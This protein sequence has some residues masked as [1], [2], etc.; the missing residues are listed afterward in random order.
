ML[1]ELIRNLPGLM[2]VY[3][4]FILAVASPGPSNLQ[5]MATSMERGRAAGSTLALGVT[6]GSLTWGILAAVGV[7]GIVV[8]HPGAL[9]AI[10]IVGGLY[11]LFL[12]WRSARSAMRAEMPPVKAAASGRRTFLRG[13][14]MHITN[15]KA[16]LSWTAIIALALRPDTP[17]VVLYAIIGGC[18]LISLAINQFYAVLFSTASMI[19]GY[20]RI[21][22]RAEA[23]LAAFFTFASFKL[24]TSQL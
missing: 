10:K 2:L 13:Y 15:P 14:L 1:D 11:L 19:A 22:R 4:A 20:R 8:A 17:P 24:L 16:I 7:T 9:Y 5:V 21:R 12:A 6:A 18:M 23:C 3:S